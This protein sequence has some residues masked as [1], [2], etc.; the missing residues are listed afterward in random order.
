MPANAAMARSAG[1]IRPNP[2]AAPMSGASL[3][4]AP[5]ARRMTADGTAIANIESEA[6]GDLGRNGLKAG[7][8]K[9]RMTLA[10][11]PTA[12]IATSSGASAGTPVVRW[13]ISLQNLYERYG[14]ANSVLRRLIA[15][16]AGN[17]PGLATAD[18]M[19]QR[20]S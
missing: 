6:E 17:A 10:I 7:A 9:R 8:M 14:P 18:A 3:T 1:A 5:V 13:T 12:K 4:L 19:N 2:I 20:P 16:R 11:T 15:G